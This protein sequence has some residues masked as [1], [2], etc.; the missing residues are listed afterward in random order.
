MMSRRFLLIMMFIATPTFAASITDITHDATKNT[1]LSP[2]NIAKHWGLSAQQ[3]KRYNAY[4][5]IEGHYFYKQLDPVFVAGLI[6][7]TDEE[8]EQLAEL[9]AKQEYERNKRLIA[10]NDAFEMAAD[11]LYGHEEKISLTKLYAKYGG[12]ELP[13]INSPVKAGDHIAVFIKQHCSLC[14]ATVQEHY[15]A[16][17]GYPNG[18]TLDV[19][20]VDKPSDSAIQNWAHDIKIDVNKVRQRTVTLNRDSSRY[21]Q[22]GSPSLPTTYLLRNHK[23]LGSL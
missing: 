23:I 19:Y 9:Y 10:F 20:F 5:K 14:D 21:K 7:Q 8:R 22:Y 15:A 17:A 11:R 12:G 16:L 4:M 18:V 1:A 13:P 6:A 2:T 3:L